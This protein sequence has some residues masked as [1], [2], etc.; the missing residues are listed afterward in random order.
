[1][2]S[3]SLKFFIYIISLAYAASALSSVVNISSP[4]AIN[5]NTVS[6]SIP[7]GAI[8]TPNV[9]NNPNV[10]QTVNP[11]GTQTNTAPTL[12]N[13][14]A[15]YEI[16]SNVQTQLGQDANLAGS[17]IYVTCQNGIVTLQGSVPILSKASEAVKVA[18]KV[19]GV[20][21]V[22]SKLSVNYGTGY[23]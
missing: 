21:G 8:Y 16:A 2:M 18:S 3:S 9:V 5:P 13:N 20:K 23:Q 4:T 17:V 15:D 1:M 10:L 11:Y 14:S 12:N 22:N 7:N 6:R 19:P